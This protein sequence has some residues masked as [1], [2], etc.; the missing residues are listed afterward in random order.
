[1]L[2]ADIYSRWHPDPPVI[3]QLEGHLDEAVWAR[4][5]GLEVFLS[6]VR[7]VEHSHVQVKHHSAKYMNSNY[8][9]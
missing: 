5:T 4:F 2:I 7:E 6:V 8:N 3:C 9:T 1:M